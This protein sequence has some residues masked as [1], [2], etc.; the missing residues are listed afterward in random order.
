[1][2]NL[3]RSLLLMTNLAGSSVACRQ[4]EGSRE[5]ELSTI[6]ASALSTSPDQDRVA[7]QTW[8]EVNGLRLDD[9]AQTILRF[10]EDLNRRL[11]PEPTFADPL[12]GWHDLTEN[13]EFRKNALELFGTAMQQKRARIIG[14]VETQEFDDC[15]A[16]GASNRWCC[17]GTLVGRN[18]V[19]TAAHCLPSC[20]DRVF[21][22]S[23]VTLPGQIVRVSH[24]ERHP[25][26][27]I[28]VLIL[29]ED[30][31]VAPRRIQPESSSAEPAWVRIVGFGN[32]DEGGTTGYGKR[33]RV[34]VPVKT[35]KCAASGEPQLYGCAA[36]SEFVAAPPVL[37]SPADSCTGDSGGPAY[38]LLENQWVLCG[39]VSRATLNSTRTCGDGG[40]YVRVQQFEEWIRSVHGGHW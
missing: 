20:A 19:L 8:K 38:A 33:R 35:W 3:I 21:F 15:V 31:Q 14:G 4:P 12:A 13:Q 11:V 5:T 29:A 40:I 34:D 30:A 18:V 10:V 36:E 27:D 2:K 39:A 28:A 16:V 25:S 24:S 7:E 6:A 26:A 9:K 1:M 37:A 32:T 17:S 22:G 23:D